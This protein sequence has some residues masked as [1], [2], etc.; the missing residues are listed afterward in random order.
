LA[1]FLPLDFFLFH[2]S[3]DEPMAQMEN[4]QGA[5]Q[6]LIRRVPLKIQA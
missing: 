1:Y 2:Y 5:A 3:D 4:G 6:K